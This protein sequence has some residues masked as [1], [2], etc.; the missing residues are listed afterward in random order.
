M[1]AFLFLALTIAVPVVGQI[2]G[3]ANQVYQVSGSSCTPMGVVFDPTH[4]VYIAY[5]GGYPGCNIVTSNING[6]VISDIIGQFDYRGAW[7]NPLLDRVELNTY[8]AGG[9]GGYGVFVMGVDGN[10]VP[11]GSGPRMYSL[12]GHVDQAMCTYNWRQN[13]IWCAT[14]SGPNL[15]VFD[16]ATGQQ[17]RNVGLSNYPGD[18]NNNPMAIGYSG[19]LGQEIMLHNYNTK[20]VYF[21]DLNGVYQGFSQL[22]G[23]SPSP[24]MYS[25][26]WSLSPTGTVWLWLANGQ[27]WYA[28][29]VHQ[30][31]PLGAAECYLPY[32]T[33]SDYTRARGFNDGD[34]G[35]QMCEQSGGSPASGVAADWQG[36]GWYRFNSW[37]T[38]FAMPTQA[39]NPFDC[40]THAGGWLNG[41]N[42]AVADG[43]VSRQVCFSWSGQPCWAN[44]QIEVVNCGEFYLYNLPNVPGN[45]LRYCGD[46]SGIKPTTPIPIPAQ[47]NAS[48]VVLSDYTRG[49]GFNDGADGVQLCEN[50]GGSGHA[51]DWVGAAW[52]RFNSASAGFAMPL[53]APRD[54]SCGTQAG[55]WLNGANP[56]MAEGVVSREVCFSFNGEPCSARSQ[57]QMV[58]CPGFFLYNLPTPP[59][60]C[61]RYCGDGTGIADDEQCR[62]PYSVLD[63]SNRAI[64]FNDGDGGVQICDGQG[65][66]GNKYQGPG[67]YRIGGEAGS[68]IPTTPSKMFDCGTHAGGWI[69]TPNP[70]MDAGIVA[71]RVCWSWSGNTC[72]WQDQIHMVTCNGF[73]LYQ[74]VN[75]MTSCLRY[76]GDAVIGGGG[77]GGGG[78]AAGD[79]NGNNGLNPICRLP[80]FNFTDYSRAINF[81]DG[82]GRVQLC[83]NFGGT[84]PAGKQNDWMGPGWY[85]FMGATAGTAMPT[86]APKPYACGTHS[87]GWLTGAQPVMSDGVV[88]RTVC[89]AWIGNSCVSNVTIQAISCGGLYRYNLPN[90]PGNCLRYCGDG[91]G[92]QEP[93]ECSNPYTTLDERT[94][95]MKFNDGDGNVEVCDGNQG[96]GNKWQ[97]PGWYRI[98]GEAGQSIPTTPRNM[99]DCGTDAGGWINTPNP[100]MADGLVSRTVCWSWAGQ[101]CLWQDQIRMVACAEFYLYFLVNPMTG[102]LRYCGD[103][104]V[105]S[106]TTTASPTTVSPT[107][108]SPTSGSPTTT[109]EARPAD[110]TMV[111][112][113][114]ILRSLDIAAV[115]VSARPAL[116]A[117]IERALAPAF[118]DLLQLGVAQVPFRQTDIIVTGLRRIPFGAN[119][120]ATRVIYAV[121][122]LGDKIED[123]WCGVQALSGPQFVSYLSFAANVTVNR[124]AVVLGDDCSPTYVSCDELKGLSCSSYIVLTASFNKAANEAKAAADKAAADAA[125]AASAAG[126]K[127][128]FPM[129]GAII[130]GVG[131]GLLFIIFAM[132]IVLAGRRRDE[133][134]VQAGR[135]QSAFENPAYSGAVATGR[136]G[137]ANPIYNDPVQGAP[138]AYAD[139]AVN[140]SEGLYDEAVFNQAIDEGGYLDV[141]PEDFGFQ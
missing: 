15:M 107:S 89:F 67:W 120:F 121:R 45:C 80:F 20:R 37:G 106:T 132:L 68:S 130:V 124:T 1:A 94:R 137:V 42:P 59:G 12:P 39:T 46:G 26:S 38:G 84:P 122:V 5:G 74:L 133:P 82:D 71:R 11:V 17:I 13:E 34:G 69:D 95:S 4:K 105:K 10:G 61:M 60:N 103:G 48:Y 117:A 25:C 123:S 56:T 91:S 101:S 32:N 43:K 131:A 72:L 104:E 76:C 8:N 81:N 35:V 116:S 33:L 92:I 127:G 111:Q 64:T 108:V 18:M 87:G 139:Q 44:T 62:R 47:C 77:G 99:Y 109:L 96:N 135:G 73:Y 50:R 19:I 93:M 3:N 53:A 129:P 21:F 128:F 30:G 125:A 28:Y 66:N 63:E 98:D 78:A 115:N 70:P 9:G 88:D 136:T 140:P 29:E 6:Q 85:Q 24:N 90:P 58:A 55:G 138:A 83:E 114:L 118:N 97:G 14:L 57:I 119:K 102:C 51:N 79:A 22:P 7:W 27:S 134:R 40:G 2:V 54:Y 41:R 49:V 36:A 16:H 23:G 52:Y 110:L 100:V 65:G 126:S 141:S 31:H 113:S 112:G 75:P 86:V